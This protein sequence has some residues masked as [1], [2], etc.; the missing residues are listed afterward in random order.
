MRYFQVFFLVLMLAA[1]A[2]I[3]ETDGLSHELERNQNLLSDLSAALDEA[4]QDEY[5]AE[6]TYLRVLVTFGR[7]HPFV[8]VIEA[9]RRH[10]RALLRLY[11]RYGVRKPEPLWN[12]SNVPQFRTLS[13]ACAHA[14]KGEIKNIAMYDRL[15]RQRGLPGDVR[16][17]FSQLRRASRQAH[18]PA[19]ERCVE[20]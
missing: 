9:E 2:A 5:Q 16:I 3:T 11:E 15:L 12:Q 7:V 14:V 18:L 17:V 1:Q 4:I 19:F 6:Q 10:I 13:A 8:N 20:R